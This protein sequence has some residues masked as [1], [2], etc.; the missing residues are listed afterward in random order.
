MNG[1]IQITTLLLNVLF[2][3][4]GFVFLI[5][6]A[7]VFVDG[8]TSIAKILKVP[9]LVIGLTIVAL[10]TSLPE[11]AVSVIAALEGAGDMSVGN[12]VGSNIFN[13]SVVLGA[14]CLLFPIAIQKEVLS[15]ELP[16]VLFI[17][18]LLLILGL[19][20]QEVSLIAG[21]IFL[22][23]L[24]G[25]VFFLIYRS[26]KQ[27]ENIE[28]EVEEE[29]EEPVSPFKSI[30]FLVLGAAAIWFGGEC[31][32]TTSVVIAKFFGMEENLIALTIV[33]LGTSLPELVTSLVAAKKGENDVA[34]GN[35]IG[36]NTLNILF[37][38]GVA[39]VISPVA[40][41]EPM[42]FDMIIMIS[43]TAI[44]FIM[45]IF[46]HK[47][48]GLTLPCGVI[49]LACYITYLTYIIIRNYAG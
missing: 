8:A 47:K 25:Y 11:L 17:S 7:D 32:N 36:S 28:V 35:V 26:K 24:V 38:L 4:V 44:L 3:I 29:S 13:I 22:V 14:T 2:L 9:A 5:K 10:G 43:I 18:V 49:L 27:K 34:L 30:I 15:F 41:S 19:A 40:I 37:I 39:G 16:V 12:V 45:A 46:T 33:A 1:D 20:F 48:K 42:I 31:V 6:G 23:M 21:I